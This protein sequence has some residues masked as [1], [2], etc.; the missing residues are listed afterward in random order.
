MAFDYKTPQ[1]LAASHQ[2]DADDFCPECGRLWEAPAPD[3]IQPAA[4]FPWRAALLVAVGL[5]LALTFGVRAARAAQKQATLQRDLAALHQCFEEV[6]W[7]SSCPTPETAEGWLA[8]DDLDEVTARGQRDR[9]LIATA[10]GL[11][12]VGV[13]LRAMARHRRRQDRPR[14]TLAVVWRMGESLIALT[15]LQ[16]L[17]LTLHSIAGQLS[18]GLPLAWE[19]LDTAADDVLVLV[20]L[21]TGSH[22]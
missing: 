3:R 8:R 4:A 12:A 22:F 7:D 19:R 2:M 16:V 1:A 13:E 6:G 21:L 10:L 14:P 20:S 9:A 5:V 18:Q 17:G 15:C 11:L